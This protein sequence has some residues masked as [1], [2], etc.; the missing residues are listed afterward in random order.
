MAF[1]LFQP[2]QKC[3]LL[4][5]PSTAV[6]HVCISAAQTAKGRVAKTNVTKRKIHYR[7]INLTPVRGTHSTWI[8]RYIYYPKLSALIKLLGHSVFA[9]HGSQL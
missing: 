8:S 5:S 3:S 4:W 2:I 9:R 6:L 7:L 1:R